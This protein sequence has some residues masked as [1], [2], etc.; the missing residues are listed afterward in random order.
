YEHRGTVIRETARALAQESAVKLFFLW[1]DDLLT[2]LQADLNSFNTIEE[3]GPHRGQAVFADGSLER[4]LSSQCDTLREILYRHLSISHEAVHLPEWEGTKGLKHRKR[5]EYD[6]QRLRDEI[7]KR[8][9]GI[10]EHET[11]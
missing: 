4:R 5:F 8:V 3:D 2:Q 10:G 11:V 7:E 1:I 6:S 9:F